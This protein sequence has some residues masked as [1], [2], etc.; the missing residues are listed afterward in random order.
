MR[1]LMENINDS[2]FRRQLQVSVLLCADETLRLNVFH[3]LKR[4]WSLE[5]LLGAFAQL[6]LYDFKFQVTA[7]ASVF[8]PFFHPYFPSQ[9]PKQGGVSGQSERLADLWHHK[10]TISRRECFSAHFLTSGANRR[11]YSAEYG[12]FNIRCHWKSVLASY[13]DL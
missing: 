6:V 8:C 4:P 13:Q 3:F 1:R 7:D 5:R 10:G 11:K 12:T 9:T 2:S